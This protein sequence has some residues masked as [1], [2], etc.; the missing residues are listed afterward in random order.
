[1]KTFVN[2]L[3]LPKHIQELY[4][5]FNDIIIKDLNLTLECYQLNNHIGIFY[6]FKCS[7]IKNNT[8]M[9]INELLISNDRGVKELKYLS[10]LYHPLTIRNLIIQEIELRKI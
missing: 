7:D 4:D 5:I 3:D 6:W 10:D 1:M 9:E 8:I 2:Y